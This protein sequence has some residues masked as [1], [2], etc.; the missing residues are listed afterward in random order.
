[1]SELTS[2]K[3]KAGIPEIPASAQLAPKPAREPVDTGSKVAIALIMVLSSA[4]SL[5]AALSLTLWWRT[6]LWLMLPG[7]SWR[8]RNEK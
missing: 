1:M 6:R 4:S 7:K 5:W 8:T 2:D 3:Q